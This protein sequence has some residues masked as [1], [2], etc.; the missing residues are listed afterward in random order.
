MII[1]IIYSASALAT[2]ATQMAIAAY[3]RNIGKDVPTILD[4]TDNPMPLVLTLAWPVTI[5]GLLGISIGK[6]CARNFKRK[7]E[8]EEEY[9]RIANTSVAELLKS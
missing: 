8:R 7:L 2:F 1:G 5:V 3:R 9:K 4:I 6:R